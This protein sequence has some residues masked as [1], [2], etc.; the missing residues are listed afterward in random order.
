M[1]VLFLCNCVDGHGK[2]EANGKFSSKSSSR[3]NDRAVFI[4]GEGFFKSSYRKNK[5]YMDCAL[6]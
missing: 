5:N 6:N 1:F 4:D 2:T 3:G